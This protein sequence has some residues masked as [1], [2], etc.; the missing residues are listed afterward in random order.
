M[1]VY[2][3]PFLPQPELM[4]VGQG[5]LQIGSGAWTFAAL[6]VLLTAQEQLAGLHLLIVITDDTDYQ[7]NPGL[8]SYVI[9]LTQHKGDSR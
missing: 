4:L 6:P 5:R 8:N 9:V 7:N 3:E 1:E 2:V